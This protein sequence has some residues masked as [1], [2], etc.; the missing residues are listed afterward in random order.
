VSGLIR[1]ILWS[2]GCVSDLHLQSCRLQ[3]CEIPT[4]LPC[5]E[6][7]THAQGYSRGMDKAS[8]YPF[9]PSHFALSHSPTSISIIFRLE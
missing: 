1:S 9:N 5:P 4:L 3:C 2:A 7:A 8:V 6:R